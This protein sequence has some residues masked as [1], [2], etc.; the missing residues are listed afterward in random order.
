MCYLCVSLKCQQ[1]HRV[2]SELRDSIK[3]RRKALRRARHTLCPNGRSEEKRLSAMCGDTLE[4]S[5][6]AV[7]GV[8][9]NSTLAVEDSSLFGFTFT[10]LYTI[11]PEF[12]SA[13]C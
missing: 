3:A 7:G 10:S 8:K 5:D 11:R 12:R 6:A 2:P 4:L 13:H 1:I 9:K